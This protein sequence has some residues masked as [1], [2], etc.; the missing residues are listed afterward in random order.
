MPEGF[1]PI[2]ECAL[3]LALAPKSNSVGAAYGAAREDALRT[4]H[5]PVPLHLRNAPTGLMRSMG[6]GKGYRYAHNEPG[7]VARGE[8]YLPDELGTPR[9]YTPG[10]LG[11][12]PGLA[13]RFARFR[14]PGDD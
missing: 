11:A 13:E 4:A 3:Y 14:D 6:Y 9:Y 10:D 7:H 12:E 8:R 1:Y 2:A 5:L